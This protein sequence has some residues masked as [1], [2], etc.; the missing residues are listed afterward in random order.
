MID[1][2]ALIS[3]T[4]GTIEDI[5]PDAVIKGRLVK[6]D[7]VYNR[8]T[9][10][11]SKTE[12]NSQEIKAVFDEIEELYRTAENSD[13]IVSK[14]HVFG[15]LDNPV[16]LFDDLVLSLS[17]GDQTYKTEQL[18]QINVGESSVLHT[19]IITR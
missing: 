13:A 15:L 14:I 7:N 8:A 5:I 18:K 10:T 6:Y 17:T 9:A 12:T 4:F 16:E 1:L 3:E 11:Y 19:F 2:N